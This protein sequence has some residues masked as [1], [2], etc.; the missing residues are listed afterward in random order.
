MQ[1]V[2]MECQRLWRKLPCRSLIAA[3]LAACI[4]VAAGRNLLGRISVVSGISMSPTFEPGTWVRATPISADLT[5]G[6]VVVLDDGRSEYALKRV[7]GLPG[8]TVHLWRGHVF[9]NKRVL[10][11]PY[12]PRKIYTFPREKQAVF[13]LGPDQYFVLGDNR[14]ASSDSRM[15][16]PVERG[17]IKGRISLPGAAPQPRFG[18]MVVK[19]YG[20]T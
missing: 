14:P 20:Q 7:V 12:I 5:R 8:E 3:V 18:A 4:G 2:L 19:P 13:V 1:Q 15:Y 6:D 16:G 9:I 10:L 17:H 11:E